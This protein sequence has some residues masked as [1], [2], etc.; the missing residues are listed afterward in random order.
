[1]ITRPW[2]SLIA[3]VFLAGCTSTGVGQSGPELD[4]DDL[5][6]QITTLEHSNAPIHC[7]DVD[8]VEAGAIS[9]CTNS[10]GIGTYRVT[11]NDDKG[12]FTVVDTTR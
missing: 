9:D 8:K 1:M 12:H 4:G 7:E 3:L 11:F 2:A 10:D 5:G 6:A